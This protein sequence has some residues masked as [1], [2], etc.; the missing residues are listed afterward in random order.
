MKRNLLIL[1]L[2]FTLAFCATA[3]AAPRNLTE[4]IQ[5]AKKEGRASWVSVLRE[6]EAAPFVKA[7]QK[8]YGIKVEYQRQHGGQAM[9]RLLREYQTGHIV[10]DVVQI[11]PDSMDE[12][13][14]LDAIEI[15]NWADFGVKPDFIHTGSRF[16][17]PFETP[18]CIIYNKNLLKPEEA[19]K[20][21]E[22]LLDPKWKGKIVTDTRPS[23]FL[24][25]T[26]AWG[27]EKMLDY[28]R[29]FRKNN[30]ITVRGQT[31]VIT[32]MAAGE[33][34]LGA[35]YYL[36][37]YVF[38]GEQKGGPLGFNLPNPLPTSFYSYG[39]IKGAKNPNA[40]KLLLAWLGT[41]GYKMMDDINWGRSA[42]FG[43]TK[44]E[45]LYKGLTLALPPPKAMVPDRR[46]YVLEMTQALG[47]RKKKK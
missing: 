7:F 9:E 29:K 34:M 33:Y 13:L 42:P 20:T 31:Q 38:D 21:W 47:V 43:G 27:P 11:H 45:P 19:P 8:E 26:G 39:I 30:P 46:K 15:V 2:I 24:R 10:Y 6:K 3:L 44:K 41:K 5:A 1:F 23:G 25:L 17:G 12:F 32:L 35:P 4:L 28:L 37:S 36:H 22:D 16:V 14:E 18:Y 40:G